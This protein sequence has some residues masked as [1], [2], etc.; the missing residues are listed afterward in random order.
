MLTDKLC[1]SV[2]NEAKANNKPIK[3][4]DRNGL[5]LHAQPNGSAY[6][7]YKYR[8]FGKEKLFTLGVY[9]MVSLAEARDK[10]FEAYKLVSEKIDPQEVRKAKDKKARADHENTFQLMAE[11][12][13]ELNKAAWEPSYAN[14]VKRRMENDLYPDLANRPIK[15][16][17]GTQLLEVL[18]KIEKREAYEM[19]RRA[20]S[21][22]GA[23]F[24]Y[25]IAKGRLETDPSAHLKELLSKYKKTHHAALEAKDI[26]DFIHK[27]DRN[28]MQLS[29][30]TRNLVEL[31]LLTFPRTNEL[32]QAR[33]EH[34]DRKEKLWMIPGEMMKM[35]NDHIV[36]L[37]RQAM[38]IVNRQWDLFPK[39]PYLFPSKHSTAKHM[40]KGTILSALDAMGYRNTHTGHGFRAL[41]MS[42]IKEKLKYQ[43]EIVD[44]QLAHAPKNS[45]D[46]AYDR[47]KYLDDRILMMQDWA[48]YIDKCRLEAITRALGK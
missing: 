47:A 44:R 26:P 23:V 39:N 7:R 43:H 14:T 11:E 35:D 32:V 15:N 28:E 24:R 36:P 45:V 18:Q 29:I 40:S 33:K 20:L 6:W 17:T 3:K 19:A 31:M 25:C 27:L 9:P 42:T 34:F 41:A 10:H 2:V 30:E 22:A 12:W 8:M 4:A 21:I 37:S 5:Y 48:D 16:I 38:A 1:K 46:K 13:Y